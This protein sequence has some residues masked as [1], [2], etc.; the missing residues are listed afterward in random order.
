MKILKIRNV[1]QKIPDITTTNCYRGIVK[2]ILPTEYGMEISVEAG[3][4]FFVDISAD[5]FMQQ[6]LELMDEVWLSFSRESGV[7]L[8]GSN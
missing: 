3:E 4:K 2:E 1:S 8:E 7:A 6:P 5:T